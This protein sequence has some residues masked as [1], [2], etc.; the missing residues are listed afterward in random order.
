MYTYITYICIHIKHI[1]IHTQIHVYTSDEG[2]HIHHR[3][4]VYVAGGTQSLHT[5]IIYTYIHT[6]IIYTHTI[7]IYIYI[8]IY[9]HIH[10]YT[11]DEGIH[12]HHRTLVYTYKH[13]YIH[14]HNIYTYTQTYM[15]LQTMRE[16]IYTL[17][18][19]ST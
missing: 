8:Y 1:Y 5:F 3:T 7:Y 14:T 4:L 9:T 15:C 16:H 19:S 11:G 18:F 10:V 6:Y 17:A 12:I 2:I 13:R